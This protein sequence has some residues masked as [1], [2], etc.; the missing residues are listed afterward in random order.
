MSLLRKMLDTFTRYLKKFMIGSELSIFPLTNIK[1]NFERIH[2]MNNPKK[3]K[4]SYLRCLSKN[5]KT[6][7]TLFD[8]TL[9]AR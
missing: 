8:K 3:C 5:P 4:I 2:V 6:P 7:Q 9:I 1:V